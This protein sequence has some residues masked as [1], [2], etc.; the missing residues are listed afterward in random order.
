MKNFNE[1]IDYIVAAA[2][3]KTEKKFR[4]VVIQGILAGMFI[5]MGAIGYFN[6]VAYTADPGL[7]KFLGALIF[8]AG[9]IAI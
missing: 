3:S 9:I 5:A 1:I 7:G 2:K 6:L 8:P 4:A